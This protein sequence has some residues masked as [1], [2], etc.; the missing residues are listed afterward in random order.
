M[1]QKFA[2]SEKAARALALVS[3][4]QEQLLE[5]LEAAQDGEPL[6]KV[7]WLRDEG[8][9]GGGWR[10]V[11]AESAAFN[12]AALNVSQVHYD[13]MA[14]K[15]LLSATAL[16]CI[17]H[18]A[19]PRVPSIHTHFS[20]TEMRAGKSY[21][22]LMADLNPSNP[23]PVDTEA[24]EENLRSTIAKHYAHGKDQGAKYFYIPPLGRH[25]GVSH[26][27]LEGFTTGSF[28]EDFAL[29]SKV[30]AGVIDTYGS[31][32]RTKVGRS[33]DATPEEVAAQIAYHTLY[34][35]QVLTLDR[36][37]TS[38]LMVHNQND[39]GIMGSLPSYIDR[40][41][42]ATWCER[43][44][45]PRDILVQRLVEALPKESP[46]AVSN[47]TRGRLAE[48]VRRFYKEHPEALAGQARGDIVPPTVQ[49]HQA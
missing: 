9:H 14:E 4:R 41:L 42:L 13:D 19:H 21:W 28:D 17:V 12:R 40:N 44:D 2:S 39:I 45:A 10:Y 30:S 27:Y 46:A 49:N 33:S 35:F 31:I 7:S 25:R 11:A 32:L 29:A 24:F 5:H 8:Q 1:K 37:T 18:P 6:A 20:Y 36:G 47:E 23:D 38:G 3:E 43:V 26:F 34:L 48:V 22:R 15:S 16:S